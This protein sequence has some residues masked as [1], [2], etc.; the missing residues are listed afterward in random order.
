MIQTAQIEFEY[1]MT[2]HADLAPAHAIDAGSRI[3]NV[4][5][6]T[7]GAG[8]MRLAGTNIIHREQDQN[9]RTT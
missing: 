3:V 8:H 7:S 4:R 1:L 5:D 9:R 6:Q 2:F